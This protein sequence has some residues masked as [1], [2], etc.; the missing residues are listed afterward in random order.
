MNQTSVI[1]NGEKYISTRDAC[2]LCGVS[3][4]TF[5]KRVKKGALKQYKQTNGYVLYSLNEINDAIR[6]GVFLKYIG[7]VNL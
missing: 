4:M 6:R 5:Y 3:R 7:S 1:I 2:M